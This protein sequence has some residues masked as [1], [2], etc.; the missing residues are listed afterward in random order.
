RRSVVLVI[1]EIQK[2]PRWSDAVKARWDEDTRNGTKVK[3][4]LLGSSP[5]LMQQG[6]Q[7][8][9]AGRFE[10]IRM[11][12]WSYAEMKE[13]FGWDLDRYLFHGGYPGSARLVNDPKRWRDYVRDTLIET[14]IARDVLHMTRIDKPA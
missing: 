13:A 10:L 2:I 12:Q 14:S 7:E 8:S 6:L 1:D 5:L 9:L 4:V 3:V 11:Q